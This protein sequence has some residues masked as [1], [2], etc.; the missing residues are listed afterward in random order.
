MNF[1]VKQKKQIKKI[2]KLILANVIA[3]ESDVRPSIIS[4]FKEVKYRFLTEQE[5]ADEKLATTVA[6]F[7]D[8]LTDE[9]CFKPNFSDNKIF[10][11]ILLHEMIHAH[12]YK[13]GYSGLNY[14]D[15]RAIDEKN[16]VMEKRNQMIDESAT[17][18]Y[19]SMFDG[20]SPMSYIMFVPIYAHLSDVCGYEKLMT[21]YFSI[22]SSSCS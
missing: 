8:E 21:L 2:Q 17:E 5:L 1:S 15:K 18:F 12:S 22:L 20:S 13:N 16:F 9:I 3:C 14:V 19:A 7:F 4:R 10:E 6:A 11:H